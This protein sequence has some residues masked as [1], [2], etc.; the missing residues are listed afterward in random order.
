MTDQRRPK[1]A[2]DLPAPPP[3][4]EVEMGELRRQGREVRASYLSRTASMER[5]GTEE[6]KI[7]AK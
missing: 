1:V 5:L 6:L 4:T 3:L 7:R 2:S